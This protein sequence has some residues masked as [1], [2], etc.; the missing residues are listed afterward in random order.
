MKR[1]WSAKSKGEGALK[2]LID[3]KSN[4][5]LTIKMKDLILNLETLLWRH[6]NEVMPQHIIFVNN[7][8][9]FCFMIN[10]L[11]QQLWKFRQ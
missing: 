3:L 2:G 4:W 8:I 7:Y 1:E 9:F 10:F 11:L 6:Y 5:K